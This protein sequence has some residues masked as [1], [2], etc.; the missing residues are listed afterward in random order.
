MNEVLHF[1]RDHIR[2]A[3]VELTED[4][5]EHVIELMEDDGMTDE[6][7]TQFIR[8]VGDCTSLSKVL[9]EFSIYDSFERHVRAMA[10]GSDDAK[11]RLQ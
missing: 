2:C 3:P 8:N 11:E 7:R 6:L 10:R 5:V 9:P 4:N 1:L